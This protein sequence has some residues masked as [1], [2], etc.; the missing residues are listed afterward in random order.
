MANFIIL[1]NFILGLSTFVGKISFK[2]LKV[3]K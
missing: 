1:A 3:F 2:L